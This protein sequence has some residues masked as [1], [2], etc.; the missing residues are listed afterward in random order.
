[1]THT[2]T[3]THTPRSLCFVVCCNPTTQQPSHTPTPHPHPH[4]L[5]PRTV[6]QQQ[7]P[8]QPQQQIGQLVKARTA[9]ALELV[10]QLSNITSEAVAR[11]EARPGATSAAKLAR[12]GSGSG[13][14]GGV[15]GD[16]AHG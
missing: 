14:C 3:H 8:E 10:K 15:W 4:P 2:Y 11:E 9:S 13:A 12:M 16:I 7:H 5:F 1:M 6:D